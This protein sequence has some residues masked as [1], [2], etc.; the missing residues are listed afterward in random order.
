MGGGAKV[1]LKKG[2]KIGIVGCSNAQPIAYKNNI[3]MFLKTI[4]DIGLIPLCSN[5]IFEKYDTIFSGSAEERA[6][7]LMEFYANDEVKAIFDISGGDVA[8][9]ILE[10]IDFNFIRNNPKPFFG[11]SD[12][13]TIINA[14]YSKTGAVSYLYQLQNLIYENKELQIN[15][16]TK[17]ILYGE[18]DLYDFEYSFLQ[19]KSMKGVVIGGNIRCLLKLA[20]TL[21]LPEF[22]N[23]ILFLESFGGGAALITTFFSQLKQM[24]A[25]SKVNGI[26]L[27]TF[28]KMEENHFRPTSEEILINILKDTQIPIAKTKEIGHGS[29][30]KCIAIGELISLI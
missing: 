16:F 17:S 22:E 28:T 25:F 8:N 19:G 30:S 15:R 29:D 11:Y 27:G 6:E 23:K 9:E 26:L 4:T 13:T 10:Y 18:K 14:L 7:A 24:G 20:G 21:Y 12:L 5:C 3:D 2:D 1:Q